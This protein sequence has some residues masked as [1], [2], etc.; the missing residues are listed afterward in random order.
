[1]VETGEQQHTIKRYCG[2]E[3]PQEETPETNCETSIS[4]DFSNLWAI[5]K[6]KTSC[7]DQIACNYHDN[8]FKLFETGNVNRCYICA[9]EQEGEEIGGGFCRLIQQSRCPNFADAGCY[10]SANWLSDWPG[11]ENTKAQ[12]Y[13]G[14]SSFTADEIRQEC[15]RKIVGGELDSQAFDLTI[16]REV[17][18]G[19]SDCNFTPIKPPVAPKCAACVAT[20]DHLGNILAGN[21]KCF[22]NLEAD[23]EDIFWVS[24]PATDGSPFKPVCE[25]SSYVQWEPNGRQTLTV[26]QGCFEVLREENNDLDVCNFETVSGAFQARNCIKTCDPT[27]RGDECNRKNIEHVIAKQGIE[28][29]DIACRSCS[30]NSTSSP[31]QIEYCRNVPSPIDPTGCPS[32]ANRACFNVRDAVIKPDGDASP[33]DSDIAYHKGCSSFD[34]TE[35]DN[36]N[37]ETSESVNCREYYDINAHR[38][39]ESCKETCKDK[40]CNEGEVKQPMKCFSCNYAWDDFGIAVGSGDPR[41]KDPKNFAP[42]DLTTCPE[43]KP[44][45][46]TEFEADWNQRGNQFHRV[47][48]GCT[49]HKSVEPPTKADN[50]ET[51]LSDTNGQWSQKTCAVSCDSAVLG[52]NDNNDI[53]DLFSTGKVSRCHSCH[54]SQRPGENIGVEDCDTNTHVGDSKSCEKYEDNGCYTAKNWHVEYGTELMEAYR[55]CSSFTQDEVDAPSCED[56]VL[57]GAG[58]GSSSV[59]TTC[60][61]WCDDD[62]CNDQVIENPGPDLSVKCI[63]CEAEMDFFGNITSGNHLCFEDGLGKEYE[64]SCD[65]NVGG[66]RVPYCSNDLEVDWLANGRQVLRIKRGCKQQTEAQSYCNEGTRG[67]VMF[68]HCQ[69]QCAAKQGEVCNKDTI[70][71]LLSKFDSGKNM[72]CREC[73]ADATM[74]EEWMEYCRN[75]PSPEDQGHQCPKWANTGCFNVRVIE[76]GEDI[77]YS[78]G[79][80]SFEVE[81]TQCTQFTAPDGESASVSRKTC[82]ASV[83]PFCNKGAVDE[84]ICGSDAATFAFSCILML[85]TALLY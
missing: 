24:C 12:F 32:W 35:E 39:T 10:T 22:E 85:F 4:S 69:E 55:G 17:C 30:A 82:D 83:T 41:C 14:C 56:F 59:Y 48:R 61:E 57:G 28:N 16:C 23:D 9:D 36:E 3:A 58:G 65:T 80:S 15:H 70:E 20:K 54:L 72:M 74:G 7:D 19:F 5:K 44:Y 6:C 71:A 38:Y 64:Q 60:R 29:S 77:A 18:D 1:M 51:Y 11:H 8:V 81:G 46:F 63:S 53:Y 40:F 27:G 52:C 26:T 45:C 78:K 79:C 2:D 33:G 75:Q 84:A 67:P 50:C 47:A 68:K 25:S 66:G 42:S 73:Y 31:E 49:S 21:P 43:D 76:N 34:F 37:V 13:H 62:R